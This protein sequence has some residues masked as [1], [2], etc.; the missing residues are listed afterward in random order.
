MKK[1]LLS[2]LLIA[3]LP[4]QAGVKKATML[5]EPSGIGQQITQVV[6]EYDEQL[7]QENLPPATAFQIND[8][9]ITH[10]S[11][12]RCLEAKKH[13]LSHEL[14][15]HLGKEDPNT[16]MTYRVT[17][18]SPSI[19]RKPAYAIKQIA[20]I[21]VFADGS[22]TESREILPNTFHTER[23][24]NR[25][26]DA[27]EQHEWRDEQGKSIKYNL[28]VPADYDPQQRYPLILFLHDTTANNTNV[29]NT[30]FQGN[31]ATVW[32]SAEWQ[33][34][35]PTFI[36]A[37]QFDQKIDDATL[38]SMLSHLM[39]QVTASYA[40]DE[41]RLYLTGQG[42]G[43]TTGMAMTQAYPSRFAASYLVAMPSGSIPT[44]STARQP[45]TLFVAEDDREAFRSQQA[46][47]EA[48]ALNGAQVQ[49]ARLFNGADPMQ[50]EQTTQQLFARYGDVY[51]L[52][53]EAGT[54][55][56]EAKED[57]SNPV[58]QATWQMAYDIIAVRDWL[59][60][61]KK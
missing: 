33:R 51:A 34:Q 48:L 53:I 49:K 40:I 2:L 47:S 1:S 7:H 11:L 12:G 43:A 29:R 39:Q 19:E 17:P 32:A 28:F 54:L 9:T 22:E 26:L 31:G 14:V 30:L 3:A 18:K 10:T 59:F 44:I 25:V 16:L 41:Q 60:T 42:S 57:S 21:R 56:K 52:T 37:P 27:F 61:Q 4:V 36:L 50:V 55:P 38:V 8:R 15:L 23:V 45:L 24:E 35:H 20:P 5:T 58:A 6:L 46:I 13:C